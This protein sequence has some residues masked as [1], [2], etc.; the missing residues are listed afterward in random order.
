MSSYDDKQTVEVEGG[1]VARSTA[2]AEDNNFRP[3]QRIML[4]VVGGSETNIPD[5]TVLMNM[6]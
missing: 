5:G 6:S 2:S 1:I 4:Q 3:L